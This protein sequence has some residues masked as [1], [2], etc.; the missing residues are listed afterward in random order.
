MVDS[1]PK[2][3]APPDRIPP[4]RSIKHY[5]HVPPTAIPVRSSPYNLSGSRLEAMRKQIVDLAD[6]GWIQPSSLPW[7]SPIL[8]VSKDEGTK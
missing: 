8:F 5:I 4:E 7:A 2:L 1:H 3:F 6:K